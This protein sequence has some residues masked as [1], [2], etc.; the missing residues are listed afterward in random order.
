MV[1]GVGDESLVVQV[2]RLGAQDYVPKNGNYLDVL[3]AVL[4]GAVPEYREV[5]EQEDSAGIAE[6]RILYIEHHRADIDLTRRHFAEAARHLVLEVVQFLHPGTDP[7]AGWRFRPGPYDLRMPDMNALDLLK[8]IQYRALE[9]P[10]IIITGHGDED[11][12]VAALKLGGYDYIVK[13]DNYLIQLPYAIDHAIARQRLAEA[14]RLLRNELAERN[15]AE[16]ENARL[17]GEVLTQR[18]RLDEIVASVP[19]IV[20]EIRGR[21]DDPAATMHFVSDHAV[22]M[23]G[24]ELEQWLSSPGFWLRI[25]HPDDKEIAARQ[26]ADFFTAGQGGISRFRWIA[27]DGRHVW[28]EARSTVIFDEYRNPVGMRGVTMDISA[29]KEAEAARAQLEE[30]LRQS[31]KMESVGRLAG[32]VAH[33]FNNLLTVINGHTSLALQQLQTGDPLRNRLQD[34]QTAGERA[35][36]LTRQLLALSRRQLLTPRVLSLNSLIADSTSMLSRLLGE[37]IELV[38]DLDPELGHVKSDPGQ[39]NQVILNLAANA[40]DAMPRGGK[41]TLETRNV[42]LDEQYASTHL[43]VPAGSYVMLCVRDSGSGMDAETASHI[44]E[45]FFTTKDPGRGTGLGLSTVYGIVKQSGGSIWVDSQPDQ[46]TSF[47]IYLPRIDEPMTG[48]GQKA[49]EPESARGSETILVVE[50]DEMVRKLAC[51]SLRIYGYQ[52]VE[53]ANAGEALLLGKAY[54]GPITLMLTDVV[55]PQMSGIELASRLSQLR[56]G[57]RVV[58]MSGYTDDAVLRHGALDP[59][60][61]FLQKPF[62]PGSLAEKVREALDSKS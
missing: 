9:I 43:S 26:A 39:V 16:E 21:P 7:V 12:A 45:P 41:L 44:F 35:S 8:E 24:Y 51:Q 57:M 25:V 27:A 52:V 19:G 10:V 58:Y 18:Q 2:L 54:Q 23:L 13:R 20:W 1:T 38:T 28:V 17:L 30:Q 11:T 53:A 3:P 4:K 14:N 40:R 59:A 6:R 22:R 50:D 48:T 60:L 15:R 33:D 62:T 56:P 31:Q 46:G 42:A 32:G 29:A 36:D 49:V 47:R 61:F 5:E 55:M 34:I 37:D